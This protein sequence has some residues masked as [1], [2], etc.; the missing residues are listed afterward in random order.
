MLM[1]LFKTFILVLLLVSCNYSDQKGEKVKET[2]PSDIIKPVTPEHVYFKLPE[3]ANVLD[4]FNNAVKNGDFRFV[5]IMKF[6]LVIP[7]IPN[8]LGKYDKSN[9]VKIIEGTSDSYSLS[10]S[11]AF[12]NIDFY[13]NYAKSYNKLLLKYLDKDTD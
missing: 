8:Y 7:G 5:G 3:N 9:G 2:K 6:T 1:C 13:D 10:D 4:D 11:I 12:K